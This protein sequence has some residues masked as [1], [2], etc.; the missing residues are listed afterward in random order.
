MAAVLTSS[1]LP[2][3]GDPLASRLR[4]D[5]LD[6]SAASGAVLARRELALQES[7]ALASPP[8]LHPARPMSES[9]TAGLPLRTAR[10][11]CLSYSTDG[12]LLFGTAV[13]DESQV[14]G[15][16]AAAAAQVYNELFAL[17]QRSGCPHLLRVWNYMA[18]INDTSDG[19]ERYRHFNIGRQQAFLAAGRSAFAGSPA[20]CALGT[21]RGPLTVHFLAG[22]HEP[23]AVENPR[24]VSAYHYPAEYGPRTPTFSRGALADLGGGSEALFISGTASIV[25]HATL[26]VGD[27]H[28]QTLETLDNIE[29][30]V[31]TAAQRSV[32]RG[33]RAHCSDRLDCTVYVRHAAN[34]PAIRAAFEQRLGAQSAAARQAV[35]LRADICRS[36]LL[37]EIEAHHIG[38]AG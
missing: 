5:R 30:V 28:Q 31:A 34:L 36:D 7:V 12:H 26:H 16:L 20:A 13:V 9:W 3:S 17:L 18:R 11:G 6:A 27:V 21:T 35:Y 1:P 37:V 33:E 4:F 2:I 19:L 32:L 24:Q 25:G 22:R 15:G 8:L 10:D 23:Q 29:A 38:H 14:D